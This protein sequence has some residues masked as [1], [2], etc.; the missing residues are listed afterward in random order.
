MP[1]PIEIVEAFL[2]RMAV[3]GGFAAA[4]RDTFTP[5]TR[6]LN[7]GLS[8]TT[9]IEES[10]A[11]AGQ[12]EAMT[13]ANAIRIET[14]SIAAAGNTVLTERIDHLIRDDGTTAMSI[15]L[16]GVFDVDGDKITAWRDYF[17]TAGMAGGN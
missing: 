15:R 10:V 11:F 4:I 16:M 3:P 7:V 6:Y 9:G 8:D 5:E 14:L 12:L 13:G 17:D 2:D 1:S